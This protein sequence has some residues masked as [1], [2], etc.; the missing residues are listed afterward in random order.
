MMFNYMRPGGV[1]WDLPEGWLDQARHL[2]LERLP[3]KVYELQSFLLEN[4]IVQER[5]VGVGRLDP[6]YAVA[7]GVSGPVLRASGVPYDIRRAEPYSV[8]DR[9]D[10]DVVTREEGDVFARLCQRFEEI[11]QS[12]RILRQALDTI[13]EGPIQSHRLSPTM[14]LPPGETY[15][16]IEA[17]KGE[18]G[19]Y[20]VSD[21]GANPYRYHVRST[22]LINLT[23][24]STLT[25]GGKIADIVAVLGSIDLTMG[26]VDR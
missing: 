12:L 24:L 2:V 13:P 11:W 5:S 21:G 8:Y 1:A 20:L 7:C 25:R 26:E 4:E 3:R 19:F 22:S 18:L 14:R 6:A 10:F 9:F 15:G 16:R 23:P 17:P